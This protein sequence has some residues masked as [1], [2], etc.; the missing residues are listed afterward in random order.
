[1]PANRTT[2]RPGS[3]TRTSSTSAAIPASRVVRAPVASPHAPLARATRA[4]APAVSAAALPGNGEPDSLIGEAADYLDHLPQVHELLQRASSLESGVEGSLRDAAAEPGQLA[5][6]VRE[7]L[8]KIPEAPRLGLDGLLPGVEASSLTDLRAAASTAVTTAMQA[9]PDANGQLAAWVAASAVVLVGGGLYINDV[10]NSQEA[11]PQRYDLPKLK[12][13]WA[14]RP[15]AATRRSAAVTMKLVSWLAKLLVDVQGGDAKVDKNAPAR[16]KEL[17]DIIAGQGPAFVKVGQGVAIRPDLLP[18]PYMEE[19]QELLDKVKPF[20]GEEARGLIRQELGRPLEEVF[21]D[22]RDFD[23]PVAAA[24]IGQVY[25]ATLKKGV[26]GKPSEV[27]VKCQRPNILESV[28]LD[29]LT[30]RGIADFLRNLPLDGPKMQQ[31]KNNA[32]GFIAVIDVAAERFL[33]ELDYVQEVAN[34]KRFEREMGEVSAITGMI[35]IPQVFDD[36]SSRYLMVSEWVE[37]RKLTELA[38]DNSPEG[39]DFRRDVVKKLLYSY[40]VQFLETGFLHADPHPGNF[41]L[42]PDGRLCILDYGMMTE[43]SEDQRYAF[44][45]YMAHLTAREYDNT[46]DDLV[47]LGF[48]PAELGNDPE[49]RA[50]VA[51]VLAKTLETIYSTG[52]GMNKKVTQLQDNQTSQT[53]ALQDKLEEIGRQYPLQLPPYFVLILRAFGTLE[54]LGLSVDDNFAVVDECFPYIAR[55]MLSD[56]SPRMRE[57]LRTFIYNGDNRLDVQRLEDV[58]KGFSN[59]TNTMDV[60]ALPVTRGQPGKVKPVDAATRDLLALLFSPEGNYVQE[61]LVDEAVRAVDALSRDALVQLW[62]RLA[63]AAPG[64][65]ALALLPT[66]LGLP[67]AMVPGLNTLPLLSVLAA[68][69]MEAIKLSADDKANL[70]TLRRLTGIIAIVSEQQGSGMPAGGLQVSSILQQEGLAEETRTLLQLTA[71]GAAA[72]GRRFAQKLS[73]RLTERLRSDVQAV[74]GRANLQLQRS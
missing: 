3:T 53:A 35:K 20:G 14:K 5:G 43:I 54:G 65:I 67:A 59:F 44:V 2:C 37:G 4:R 60:D 42:M 57:A 9:Q 72:I 8:A 33:E 50:I 21:T 46:L 63:A 73:Q 28:T 38:T 69:N 49:K 61:L 27:A 11:I 40:M 41:M 47:R 22:V 19:L 62:Q 10:V 66:P 58:A 70:E 12:E 29:I 25:K 36:L 55:R 51:P 17:K 68:R 13:Y 26:D 23:V 18:P 74:T 71:P 16:A 64:A 1:M 56:D 52:G 7:L 32:E 6:M 39:I 31:I 34:S 30:M 24:S 15:L 48:V 45:E